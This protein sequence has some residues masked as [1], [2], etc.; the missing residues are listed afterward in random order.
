MTSHWR[1][2]TVAVAGIGSQVFSGGSGKP[3]LLL[4]GGGGNPAWTPYP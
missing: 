1:A 2:D 4:H 3:I